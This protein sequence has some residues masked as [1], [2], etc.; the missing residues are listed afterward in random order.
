MSGRP[1]LNARPLGDPELVDALFLA[2]SR[3][4]Q[5][6]IIS[7]SGVIWSRPW[8]E[9]QQLVEKAGI[10]FYTTPQGRGVVPDDHPLSY[11]SMRSTAFKEA[12]LIIVLS[13]RMNYII[14]HAAPPVSMPMPRSPASTLMR[15]RSPPRR[16]RSISASLATARWC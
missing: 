12:D 3:A 6:V 16:A 13:T 11:L 4:K 7:G 1:V 5:P 2:L 15:A 10:P 14:S 9:M 8:N